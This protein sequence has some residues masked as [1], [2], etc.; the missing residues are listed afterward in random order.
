MRLTGTGDNGEWTFI[1]YVAI[2]SFLVG[3]QNLDLN[4]TQEDFQKLM[5]DLDKQTNTLLKELHGHLEA[6]DIKLAI[7]H[8]KLDAIVEEL[9]K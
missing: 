5:Q 3:L 8:A 1:D 2:I 9:K 7:I 6:Q 4:I